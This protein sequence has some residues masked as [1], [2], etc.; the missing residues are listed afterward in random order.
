M[1]MMS[2]KKYEYGECEICNSP[3]EERW[4]KQ[5]FW[6]KGDLIVVEEV[7]AGVCTRCGEKV[8]NAEVGQWLS[9]LIRNPER[10]ANAPQ[11]SVPKVKFNLEEVL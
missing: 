11:I 3:L 9:D 10:I 8:V 1:N 5:D 2:K 4:I 6:I 7:P